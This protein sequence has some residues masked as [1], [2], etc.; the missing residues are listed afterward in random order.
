VS[1]DHYAEVCAA[2]TAVVVPESIPLMNLAPEDFVDRACGDV[3]R[4]CREMVAADETPDPMTVAKRA[5]LA[6]PAVLDIVENGLNQQPENY[7]KA[8]RANRVRR[9]AAEIA[10]RISQGGDPAQE[11]P[12]LLAMLQPSR[13][14][15]L[16]LKAALKEAI[17]RLETEPEGCPTGFLDWD[18]KIGPLGNGHLIVLGARPAMG[19][20]A[21]ALNLN[22][23]N[24]GRTLFVSAEQPAHEIAMRALAAQSGVALNVL[25]SR[26]YSD[27]ASTKIFNAAKILSESELVVADMDSP[28]VGDVF[29]VARREHFTA[30]VSLIVVDYLQRLKVPGK[31]NRAYEVGDNIQ[32]LKTLARQLNIPVVVLAQVNREVENRPDKRPHM[33]DLKD[34]GVIEQEADVIAFLYRDEVYNENTEDKGLCEVLIGKN[35]H[36]PTGKLFLRFDGATLRFDLVRLRSVG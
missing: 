21:F 15:T 1:Y 28:T 4:V 23:R 34:S 30:P 8:I 26:H 16:S 18:S 27:G 3:Y 20:T 35:R 17:T 22:L 2:S 33:S 32:A 36:G 6:I 24:P 25:K 29:A 12:K 14:T 10:N 31:G 19:K 13:G 9:E 11:V 7:A 5:G